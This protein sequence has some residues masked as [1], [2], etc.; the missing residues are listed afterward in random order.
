[1][2][3]QTLASS[4]CP[5]LPC[6]RPGSLPEALGGQT[7]IVTAGLLQEVATDSSFFSVEVSEDLKGL[8]DTVVLI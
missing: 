3:Q 1:M 5:V 2:N 4:T 6:Q 8:R 7:H